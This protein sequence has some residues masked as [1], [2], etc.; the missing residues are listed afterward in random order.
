MTVIPSI[1]I[2]TE[3]TLKSQR[4]C[5]AKQN[6]IKQNQGK[7]KTK[8]NEAKIRQNQNKKTRQNQNAMQS[9][10]KNANKTTRKGYKR[11]SEHL[12]TKDEQIIYSSSKSFILLMWLK[13][14]KKDPVQNFT[15]WFFR[16]FALSL[17]NLLL[18][19]T[20]AFS[21]T[22]TLV[23]FFALSHS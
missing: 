18:S 20:L 11:S 15:T 2:S 1:S 13:E 17:A 3:C 7:N 19:Y 5:K 8:Q 6:K 10:T 23:C 14:K 12:E 22:L 21:H 16:H 4:P 9:K